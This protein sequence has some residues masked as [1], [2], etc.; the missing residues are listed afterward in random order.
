M[1]TEMMKSQGAEVANLSESGLT[2]V[3][4]TVD[5]TKESEAID[6]HENVEVILPYEKKGEYYIDSLGSIKPKPIYSFF[7]RMFDIVLSA[8]ALIVLAIPML[9]IAIAVKRSSPGPVVYRQE[10][11]GL[12]GKKFYILKFR[13]MYVDAEKNGA[14]W[15]E[16]DN[17]PRITPVGA[18]LRKFR[19]DE[20]P[21]FWLCLKGTMSLVGPRP[22][23]E[24]FYAEFE[25]YIHGF[26]ERLKVKPG[27]TGLAQINGGYDLKPEEKINW[28]IEYINKRSLWMDLKILF[29]TVKEVLTGDG[30]K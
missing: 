27:I 21:Q 29:G 24:C 12:N 22:E 9:I 4:E 13:T 5:A 6:G 16:G 7:K 19:G 14:Q 3:M 15:S 1:N 10:R 25:T 20:L 26:H 17:D 2:A 11:L 18:V 30:A 23:R 28:D 8:L